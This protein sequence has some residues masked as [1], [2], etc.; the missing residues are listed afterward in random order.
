MP[1]SLPVPYPLPGLRPA[2]SGA[3]HRNRL[4]SILP[5]AVLCYSFLL[6]SPE[7][8]VNAG[9]INLPTYRFVLLLLA[10][11]STVTLT[12]RKEGRLHFIDT[13]VA[14]VSFWIMLS[15]A[16]T[17][18]LQEGLVRGGGVV[19]DTGLSYLVARA[20]L[21]R[22]DDLRYFLII[23]LPGLMFAGFFLA[24]E[25]LS[26][27]LLL[28]PAFASVFGSA[29]GA[30]TDGG[31]TTVLV[32]E[33]RLGLL[34]AYGPFGHPILA[35]VFMASFLPLYY[36]S[37]LRSWPYVAGIAVALSAFFSVSSGAFLCLLV[38]IS[39]IA[40]DYAKQFLPKLTWW[41]ISGLLLLALTL[42]HLASQNGIAAVL[43]RVTLTP[44]TAQYRLLIW[45]FGTKTIEKYPWFGIG[46]KSWER[47]FWMHDSVDAH[48]LMLGMRHGLLVPV[49]LT[50]A[51]IY[52][53]VRLGKLAPKLKPHDKRFAIGIN[54]AIVMLFI[55]GQTVAFFASGTIAL[56]IF[57]AVLASAVS[58]AQGA[59]DRDRHFAEIAARHRS[60]LLRQQQSLDFTPTRPR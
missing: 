40:I 52:G 16:M 38:G 4:V 41:T 13:A 30:V 35:G 36:F 3:S 58:Y 2:A 42:A 22:L 46:Y 53:V 32:A 19:V 50:L 5:L 47:P 14:V 8:S 31:T 28:R 37:G 43:A 23:L 59:V 6:F 10:I 24:L 18:G 15:F 34:R 44:H 9:G 11:P 45:E 39:A 17:Y 26:G 29:G 1:Q 57:I 51:I 27:Q 21:S 49:L 20:S 54:V 60:T 7:V 33:S 55:V 25:S 12:K 48:F 56:M